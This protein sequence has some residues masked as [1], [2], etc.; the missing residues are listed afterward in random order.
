MEAGFFCSIYTYRYG[1][2]CLNKIDALIF[3]YNLLH[4]VLF[5]IV[6]YEFNNNYK[7]NVPPHLLFMKFMNSQP[8]CY[9]FTLEYLLTSKDKY[10][11]FLAC[12][13]TK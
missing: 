11:Q 10:A 7:I 2:V 12:K 6:R 3:N 4:A 9:S 5:L 13:R 1:D 8:D